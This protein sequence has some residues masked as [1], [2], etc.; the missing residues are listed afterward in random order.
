MKKLLFF[1]LFISFEIFGQT[2]KMEVVAGTTENVE[3]IKATLKNTTPASYIAGA[4]IGLNKSTTTGNGVY[5]GHEG[6]GIGVYGWS[7]N[8]HGVFGF[9]Q[10]STGGAGVYGLVYGSGRSGVRGY[11]ENGDG[12]GILG[13]AESGI[14]VKGYAQNAYSGTG[15]GGHFSNASSS[16]YAL[17]TGTGKVGIGVSPNLNVDERLDLNGRL[18]IRHETSTAGVWFNNSANSKNYLDGAFYGMLSDTQTGIFIGGGWRFWVNNSGEI[19]T[20]SMVG[21]GNRMVL[22]TANGTLLSNFQPQVWSISASAF[23][24]ITSGSAQFVKS[25]TSVYFSSGSSIMVAPVNLPTGVNVTEIAVFYSNSDPTNTLSVR[26]D[27]LVLANS[28]IGA[29]NTPIIASGNLGTV[30][31]I[32]ST[33]LT[34]VSGQNLI[35]N[36]NRAYNL[37][38]SSNVWSNNMAIYGV[39]ITYSY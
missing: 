20:T 17:I 15:I 32:Q 38:I 24:S 22:A 30:T 1:S 12:N 10:F 9:S 33:N 13:E 35:D 28:N 8:G 25:T 21:T 19:S 39:K 29:V 4:I 31:G 26:L 7:K 34:I 5:G 37:R 6:T 14:G 11:S 2:P 16:G 27:A 23:T 18:R 3:G 36:T